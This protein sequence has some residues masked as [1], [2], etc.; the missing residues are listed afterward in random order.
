MRILDTWPTDSPEDKEA[1]CIERCIFT[2]D[3]WK[4]RP[5]ADRK[6]DGQN[7]ILSLAYFLNFSVVSKKKSSKEEKK[8]NDS[9]RV[10]ELAR[11]GL[12]NFTGDSQ[13]KVF[14]TV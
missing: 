10:P 14:K 4:D 13:G 9:P 7:V 6:E 11:L 3:I 1:S 8:R 2:R 12:I 5:R